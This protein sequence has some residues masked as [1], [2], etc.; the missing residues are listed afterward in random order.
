MIKPGLQRINAVTNRARIWQAHL[1]YMSLCIYCV[2]ERFSQIAIL[3]K[4]GEV[5]VLR[6]P[7]NISVDAVKA[8]HLKC[9][10][11]CLTCLQSFSIAP[12]F[13]SL[14]FRVKQVGFEFFVSGYES[15]A[16]SL[17]CLILCLQRKSVRISMAAKCAYFKCILLCQEFRDLCKE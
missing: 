8:A 1:R 12:E 4:K 13:T 17:K 10:D 7:V 3:F 16:S 5:L 2:S 15:F 11:F 9:L 14:I 6:E